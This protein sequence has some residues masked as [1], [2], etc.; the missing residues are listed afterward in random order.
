MINESIRKAFSFSQISKNKSLRKQILSAI[1][2]L[3]LFLQSARIFPKRW[4]RGHSSPQ[5]PPSAAPE[6]SSERFAKLRQ[7]FRSK[8][9]RAKSRIRDAGPDEK[10]SAF[11][12]QIKQPIGYRPILKKQKRIRLYYHVSRKSVY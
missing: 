1:I 3:Y 4:R 8:W 2:Y 10:Q 6:R 7:Q 11:T 5:P 12:V 9:V